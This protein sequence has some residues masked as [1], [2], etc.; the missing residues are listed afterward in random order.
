VK[1]NAKNLFV[2]LLV[3]L[4]T[5]LAKLPFEQKL[6]GEL[7]ARGLIQEPIDLDTRDKLGQTTYAVAL[8]GLRSLVAAL[9]NL[10]AHV[11][12]EH[13]EWFELEESYRTITSLQPRTRYYWE[14]GSWHLAYNAYA[15]YGDKP[16]IP[17]ARRRLLQKEFLAKGRAMLEEGIEKNPN[18]WRLMEVYARLLSDPFKPQDLPAAAAAYAMARECPGAPANMIGRKYLYI[19]CRIPDRREAAWQA[20]QD[21][22][23]VPSN[24]RYPSTQ[25]IIFALQFGK[26]PAAEHLSLEE[27]YESRAKAVRN[28]S[29]YWKR[30]REG[31]PM[32]GVRESLEMLIKEFKIPDEFNPL[33]NP[34][35]RG[36][37]PELLK[38]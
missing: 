10:R 32:E 38:P 1:K 6:A 2:I 9:L 25:S 26:L 23:A 30:R 21:V 33:T 29:W 14:V 36:F 18:D 7:R 35:W 3:L 27:I 28:L 22:W 4:L 31:F 37:P 13:Q 5:G 34:D 19:V 11:H 16:G 8:G 20:A 24:R 12:F 15:D 17:E